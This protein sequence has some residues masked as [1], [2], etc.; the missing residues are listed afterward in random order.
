MLLR[1][2]VEEWLE[3]YFPDLPDGWGIPSPEW[4]S[5]A[6][7]EQHWVVLS[8]PDAADLLR[9]PSRWREDTADGYVCLCQ[10]T[11]GATQ[12][13][14]RWYDVARTAKPDRSI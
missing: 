8:S 1:W 5:R 3:L 14:S 2:F 13:P 12:Q 10:T 9:S 7:R 4:R 11:L 6:R